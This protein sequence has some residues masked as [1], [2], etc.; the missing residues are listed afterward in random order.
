[1]SENRQTERI[2]AVE[3]FLNGE[4][5]KSI[6][7]SLGRSRSWLYKW[8]KRFKPDNPSW[9]K[10]ESTKPYSNPT[11][12]TSEIEEIVK[13]IR[14][15]LYN[16][17]LFYGPQ[18]IL[19][20]L[21]DLNVEPL[22]SLSTIKRILKRHGLTHRRTGRYEPKGKLYPQLVAAKPNHIHQ[23]DFVGPRY[24]KGPL[25][26]YSLNIVDVNTARCGIKPLLNRSG[27]SML[28][29]LWSIWKRL[30]IPCHIQVDN[31]MVFYGSPTYPRGM[32]PLI[33]LCLHYGVE[34]WFI[35]VREPWRNGMVEKFNDH[36]QQKFLNKISMTTEKELLQ[37]SL[38]F[39]YRHNSKYRYSKLKGQTPLK[40]LAV[41]G[42]R[43]KFPKKEQAPRHPMKK[44]EGGRYHLIRFIRSDLR[45][46]IFGEIFPVSP[47]LEYEYVVA[48]VDVKE[49][50]LKIF[51]NNMQVDDYHYQLR[52]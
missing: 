6:Y 12:T 16:Q 7:T 47:D 21:E 39:E 40:A 36:H 29:G 33:R 14:L 32:G 43:L 50:R 17:D 52:H 34:P 24:L 25:R 11:R 13:I 10:S 45:L 18:A 35:P 49:Q 8:I 31:E 19:W 9:H 38:N 48:T 27:Q 44:P 3:R 51:L 5:P 4:K 15:N 26:F 46:N 20:E 1:M 23:A 42:E 30:G 22:P 28:D 37:G 2:L 41:S